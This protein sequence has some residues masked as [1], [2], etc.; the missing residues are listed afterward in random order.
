MLVYKCHWLFVFY[1]FC[2]KYKLAYFLIKL[3]AGWV[4]THFNPSSFPISINS[5]LLFFSNQTLIVVV[6]A[7]IYEATNIATAQHALTYRKLCLQ[8]WGSKVWGTMMRDR[9]VYSSCIEFDWEIGYFIFWTKIIKHKW[10][11]T[12]ITQQKF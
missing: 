9:N 5:C 1:F 3:Y 2:S 7:W 4:L 11:M 8:Y 10:S 12:F 6:P